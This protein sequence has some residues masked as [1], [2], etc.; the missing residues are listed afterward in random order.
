M[1]FIVCTEHDRIVRP[2]ATQ[3][4]DCWLQQQFDAIQAAHEPP[5]RTT[6]RESDA[7]GGR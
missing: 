3:C 4:F 7:N 6:I 5:S 2:P 1:S